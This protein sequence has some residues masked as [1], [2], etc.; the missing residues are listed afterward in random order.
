MPNMDKWIGHCA[1]YITGVN[2]NFYG[3]NIIIPI[4]ETKKL[5]QREV[6]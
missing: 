4:L 6:K 1:K 3:S 2:V 5:M